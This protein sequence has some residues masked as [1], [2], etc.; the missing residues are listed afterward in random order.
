[1][2]HCLR[3]VVELSCM[4]PADDCFTKFGKSFAILSRMHIQAILHAEINVYLFQIFL[5][6]QLKRIAPGIQKEAHNTQ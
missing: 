4:Q 2:S 6:Y 3:H 1:M 5:S